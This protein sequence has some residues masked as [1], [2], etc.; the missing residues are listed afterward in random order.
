MFF[1]IKTGF[2]PTDFDVIFPIQSPEFIKPLNFGSNLEKKK[3]QENL[4]FFI[5]HLKMIFMYKKIFL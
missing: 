4:Q 2:S 5:F 1:L 3:R